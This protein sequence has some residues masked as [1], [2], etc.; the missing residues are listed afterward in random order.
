[1]GATIV[2]LRSWNAQGVSEVGDIVE[3]EDKIEESKSKQKGLTKQR[4]SRDELTSKIKRL[5]G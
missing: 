2:T 3:S 4:R 5:S 1:M